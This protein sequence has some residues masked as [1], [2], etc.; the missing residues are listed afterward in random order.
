MKAKQVIY[1]VALLTLLA[2]ALGAFNMLPVILLIGSPLLAMAARR[3]L[4]EMKHRSSV[5][6]AAFLA[7][8]RKEMSLSAE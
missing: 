1:A 4:N 8:V 6:E 3:E 2:L 7:K 5:R